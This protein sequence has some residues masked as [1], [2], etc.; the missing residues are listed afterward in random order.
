M[1]DLLVILDFDGTARHVSM[2]GLAADHWYAPALAGPP[3]FS[4]AYADSGGW[5]KPALGTLRLYHDFFSPPWSRLPRIGYTLRWGDTLIYQGTALLGEINAGSTVYRMWDP[6][7][8]A[9]VL[10]KGSD[11]NGDEVDIPRAFGTVSHAIPQRT[12]TT[13]DYTYYYSG[14]TPASL[15][16][17][18]DGV[19]ITSNAVNNGDGTFHLS[20][21]PVGQVSISGTAAAT[22]LPMIADWA[23]QRLGIAGLDTSGATSVPVDCWL[24]SQTTVIDLL[25]RLAGWCGH[26]AWLSP[27]QG[28]LHLQDRT[29]DNGA[30]TL[31]AFDFF[32]VPVA[33]P[34]PIQRLVSRWTVRMPITDSSGHHLG[35]DEHEAQAAGP[36]PLGQEIAVDPYNQTEDRVQARLDALVQLWQQP[37]GS[38]TMPIPDDPIRPM[39]AVTVTD[40]SLPDP[41]G[42]TI[43]ALRFEYH[44]QNG[45]MT[46][47]GPG[48]IV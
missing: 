2:P 27:D 43:H 25:D 31:T 45:T 23:G 5:I 17:Y 42:M 15:R 29:I 8:S 34:N 35:E 21:S 47:S 6:D 1:S 16:V 40:Q 26:V 10:D 32:T 20:V 36:E 46:V 24:S 14:I 3:E 13:S 37:A 48:V 44:F 18:D 9:E 39:E 33:W 4:L 41:V 12:G 28:T 19:E 38:I 22:D 30:R 7:L 11:E